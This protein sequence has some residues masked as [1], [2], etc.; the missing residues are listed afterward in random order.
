MNEHDAE[1]C[2]RLAAFYAA[3]LTYRADTRNATWRGVLA[4]FRAVDEAAADEARLAA[5]AADEARR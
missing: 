4:A 2:K 1:R 5:L 3:F